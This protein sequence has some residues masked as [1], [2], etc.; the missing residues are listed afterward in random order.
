MNRLLTWYVESGKS[1][2]ESAK[3]RV[4]WV[5]RAGL[6][7]ALL[8]F[9]EFGGVD[10][11][12]PVVGERYILTGHNC[13]I[14]MARKASEVRE[15][16]SS[17]CLV[18]YFGPEAIFL[19]G[20]PGSHKY[21]S[22][23][24]SENNKLSKLLQMEEV[25]ISHFRFFGGHGF[26]QHVGYGCRGH[27][28]LQYHTY[29]IAASF[30]SGGCRRFAYGATFS[31]REQAVTCMEKQKTHHDVGDTEEAERSGIDYEAKGG[32]PDAKSKASPDV[33]G[34]RLS[35]SAVS[36]DYFVVCIFPLVNQTLRGASLVLKV[37]QEALFF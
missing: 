9:E 3:R 33:S 7:G 37:V 19:L 20:Y 10:L 26:L 18:L 5:V 30:W 29:L 35:P 6:L 21:V 34:W 36:R 25:K 28:G 14:Q 17:G 12:V 32:A 23:P 27:Q 1:W 16:K 24:M 2:L 13:P 22:F 31:V 8:A 15:G 11:Y 4:S